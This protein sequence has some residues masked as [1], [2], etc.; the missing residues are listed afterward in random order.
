MKDEKILMVY[1][2]GVLDNKAYMNTTE[3]QAVL[4]TLDMDE[5]A[6]RD[7]Y[8]GVFHHGAVDKSSAAVGAEA[9]KDA[10]RALPI[11][12]VILKFN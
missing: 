6:L 11:F 4:N 7:E 8:D 1:D 3:F 9:K 5:V 12:C 10:F 2:R